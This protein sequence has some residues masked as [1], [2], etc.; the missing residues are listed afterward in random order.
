MT[1]FPTRIA[2][3]EARAIVERVGA[4]RKLHTESLALARAHGRVTAQNAVAAIPLPPFDNSA[5]DGYALR[6]ADLQPEGETVLRLVGE[7]FA[8]VSRDLR[9]DTG[10]C[11]RITT[12]APMPEGADTVVMK[13]NTAIDG[14]RVRVLAAP[15][16]GAH[17]RHA[18]EDTRVGETVLRAGQVL[19]P[20]RI[21]L[22][23]SMGLAEIQV[24]RRPTV[25]VFTTGDELVEP[26]L[27]LQSGQIYNSNRELLMGLLRAD[28]L[29]PTAWPTLPDEPARIESMLRDAAQAFDL[30]ITCGAVSAGEK[31]HIP[32]LLQT[33]G[34]I[35]FWKVRMRPGMPLLFGELENA[36][37]LGLPGNPVSVLA[38]YLTLGRSL[39][40][41]MQGRAEPRSRYFARLAAP[42][43][44]HHERLEFLRG[45]LISAE[46]GVLHVEPNPADGSHRMRAAADSDALIV[47]PEQVQEYAAGAA[48]E[49][50]PY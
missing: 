35:H 17:V 6:H 26:G 5:M 49:V 12:G 50:L 48:V 44:K 20:S 16:P 7:Q 18:G 14:D 15:K 45:R 40:D 1:D 4:E 42:W 23:A 46:D 24:A 30:V 32:A 36:M 10:E 19:T 38:T 28:G 41:A 11:S 2:F 29:E 22:A 8:G 21:A 39:I 31:D 34:R 9:I 25:A 3:D 47:L 13:E 43:R 37:F 33:Q 27:P